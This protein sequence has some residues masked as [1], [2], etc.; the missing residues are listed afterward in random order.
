MAPW[1]GPNNRKMTAAFVHFPRGLGSRVWFKELALLSGRCCAASDVRVSGRRS[2]CAAVTTTSARRRQSSDS[3][4]RGPRHT[5]VDEDLGVPA[6]LVISVPL[7]SWA[8]HAPNPR[9]RTV[10][11]APSAEQLQQ[12]K[13]AGGHPDRRDQHAAARPRRRSE[14]PWPPPPPDLDASGGGR[15]DVQPR[16]GYYGRSWYDRNDRPVDWSTD[17]RLDAST[18]RATTDNTRRFTTQNTV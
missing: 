15:G 16:G 12:S 2:V 10:C 8:T 6:Q 1:N 7:I 18:L 5:D 11:V 14:T 4:V 9:R 13:P 3:D 17:R